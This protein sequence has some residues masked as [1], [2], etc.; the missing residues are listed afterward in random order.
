MQ[1]LLFPPRLAQTLSRGAPFSRLREK[2]PNVVRRMASGYT[3]HPTGH[4]LP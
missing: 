3:P 1:P 2:V 4:L